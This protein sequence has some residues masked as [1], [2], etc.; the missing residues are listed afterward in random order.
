MTWKRFG[1]F[2]LLPTFSVSF[3][4]PQK[5]DAQI[6]QGLWVYFSFSSPFFAV[7]F[8][9]FSDV[10]KFAKLDISKEKMTKKKKI[11]KKPQGP[12]LMPF[13]LW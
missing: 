2:I 3:L 10:E 7:L 9:H 12:R 5:C 1:L 11:P 4:S 8:N 13:I 6:Y